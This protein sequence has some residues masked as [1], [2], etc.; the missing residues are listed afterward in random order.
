MKSLVAAFRSLR[1]RRV[2]PASLLERFAH[3]RAIGAANDAFLNTL[4]ALSERQRHGGRLAMRAVVSA[5]ESLSAPVATM[6]KELIAMSGGR[7]EGLLAC[8]EAID[9]ELEQD[10]LKAR[11][12]EYGPIIVWPDQADAIRPQVVGPKSARL[13]E[14]VRAKSHQ[15][16]PFFA[17][18][19]YGYRIFFEATGLEDLV[20][21]TLW[22]SDPADPRSL[23]KTCET[24]R[25]AVL[26]AVVPASLA[27]AMR[28]AIQRLRRGHPSPYAVA[29]RSSA[30]V[31]DTSASF[32]GQF[33]SV[34]NVGEDG[35]LEAYKQ[36]VASKYRPETVQYALASGFL[37]EDVTMPVL[38]M[39]MIEPV[40]SGV[41]YSQR[42][43]SPG[44]SLITAVR[45]LAQ[46][47]VEGSVTPDCYLA[48]R[49]DPREVIAVVRGDRKGSTRCHP[50]GGLA[51]TPAGLADD[52]PTIDE[53]T[54]RRVAQ[55]S[56]ALEACFGAPQDVE[57]AIDRSGSLFVVQSRPVGG[58]EEGNI[59]RPTRPDLHGYRMLLRG[60]LAASRGV[61]CGRV[62]HHLDL[63]LGEEVP[64]GVVL[65]VPHT[66]PSLGGLVPRMAAVVSAGGSPTGHM[67]T[68]AREFGVPCLVAVENAFRVLEPGALVT[69]DGW[70]GTVWEGEVR[71]LMPA[72]ESSPTRPPAQDPVRD[73]VGKLL[74]RV[75]PLTLTDP[76][77]PDFQPANCR[78]LH[79]IA[80]FV[81]Q[82]SMAEMFEVDALSRQERSQARLLAW[83]FPMEVL[84]VDL[85]GGLAGAAGNT[86]QQEEIVSVPLLA[87]LEGM[88]DPRLR[89]AGPVGFDLKGFISVVVRSS[90]D[91][92]RYGHAAYALC[93]R[94]FVHFSSRLAYHFAR[95]EAIC[96][97]SLNE[98]YARFLFFGGAAAA[99]R[100]EWRAHFL[101]TVLRWNRFQV[102]QV[103]DR[104]EAVL[105]KHRAPV[106]EESLVMLGRLMVAARQLDMFIRSAAAAEGFARSFL[107]GDYAF[108]HMRVMHE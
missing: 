57:W 72:R 71:E 100:R 79:D 55:T 95:V 106:I 11:P 98:N 59:P 102:N 16:P 84:I 29:V 105:A 32:A 40:A 82:R 33:E 30:V 61:A 47:V 83:R 24:I 1:R 65:V 91:D 66:P 43:E 74:T 46:P 94:D 12:I 107:A 103:G 19:V 6:V 62:Y 64:A 67:A 13:A 60:A 90:A 39:E 99:E 68:V 15:V 70:E 34:L 53:A 96:G 50:V 56:W 27:N 88:G 101:A 77:S 44:R 73:L 9:R 80:R 75:A 87:L 48:S 38:V 97:E 89:C 23:W 26:D 63:S 76:T 92:Q 22:S 17:V 10:V 85:G 104:V 35:L 81:H 54:A 20:H 52:A 69:V 25:R 51:D 7:Y 78:T 86:V 28:G 8:Y 31:E 14:I 21:Q 5:C 45:G 49:E 37:D 41:A 4:A 108:Q 58:I 18:S 42:P 2:R 93:G 36:V 3:F